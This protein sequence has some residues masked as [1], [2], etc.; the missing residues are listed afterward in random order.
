MGL[1]LAKQM[2]QKLN[3]NISIQS[4]EGKYTKVILSFPKFFTYRD[5]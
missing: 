1:F 4:E 2:T 5:F 3:H